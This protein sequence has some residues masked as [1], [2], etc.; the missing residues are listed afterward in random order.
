MAIAQVVASRSVCLKH[1]IGAVI[2]NEDKQILSTGY[3]GPP[4]GMKHCAA[5]G[6]CIRE[7]VNISSGTRQEYCFGLRAEQNAIVQAARE[8]ITLLSST[9]YYTYKL[10]SLCARMLVNAGIKE[11]YFVADY[12]DDLTLTIFKEGGVSCIKWNVS[13]RERYHLLGR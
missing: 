9:L 8:G 6:G 7:G 11:I 1:K 13:V 10:C 2:V 4:R 5:R 3:G 12:P